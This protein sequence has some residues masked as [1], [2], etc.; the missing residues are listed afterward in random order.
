MKKATAYAVAFEA[1]TVSRKGETRKRAFCRSS[2]LNVRAVTPPARPARLLSAPLQGFN[3]P[4]SRYQPSL[5]EPALRSYSYKPDVRLA[6]VRDFHPIPLFSE[7]QEYVSDL[8]F[9]KPGRVF[10]TKAE[11]IFTCLLPS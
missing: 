3:D 10:A 5:I 11:A 8:V 9:S 7:E 1:N 4:L 2:D 6:R